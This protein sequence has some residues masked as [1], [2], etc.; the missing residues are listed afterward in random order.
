MLVAV[1]QVEVETNPKTR[2][3]RLFDSTGAYVRRNAPGDPAHLRPL[4]AAARLRHR[5][6]RRR[7]ARPRRLDA[8]PDRLDLQRRQHRPHPVAD[9]RRRPLHRRASSS[10]PS[11][12]SAT[13]L[14]G[15]RVMTQRVFERVR[16]VELA[17][18]VEPS[19]Y[20]P[21]ASPR[22]GRA[23]PSRRRRSRGSAPEP[24]QL[25][26]RHRH[27]PARRRPAK[28]TAERH[29]RVDYGK[30]ASFLVDRRRADRRHHLHLLPDRLA[31]ALEAR[32]R[33]DHGALV[34]RLH[35]RSRPSTARSNSCSP[36]TSPSTSPAAS[37]S[38]SRCGSPPRSSS[39]WR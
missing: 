14:P 16:R 22:P 32:L 2:E 33:A 9:P 17:L 12:S 15:Q 35:H 36:A 39:A 31:R 7:P 20:E 28:R 26:E 8:V 11:A 19:H 21:G 34:G 1:D 37:R 27:R 25:A 23:G 18:G 24:P 10:S 13:C 30:T 38:A 4:R 3:S 5:R 6:R 29:R